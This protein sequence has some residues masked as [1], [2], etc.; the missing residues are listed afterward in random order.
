MAETFA[1][2]CLSNTKTYP[3][4]YNYIMSFNDQFIIEMSLPNANTKII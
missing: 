2:L 3:V 1:Y 4:F